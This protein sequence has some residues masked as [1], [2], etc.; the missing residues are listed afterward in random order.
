MHL[1]SLVV[2]LLSDDPFEEEIFQARV[3]TGIVLPFAL[4]LD[5]LAFLHGQCRW[6]NDG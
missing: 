5:E 4:L 2:L 6:R 3:L 1:E